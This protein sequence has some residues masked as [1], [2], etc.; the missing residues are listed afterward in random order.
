MAFKPG[1]N[2]GRQFTSETQPKKNGR[3]PAIYKQLAAMV[4]K[5][6]KLTLS[7]EDFLKL[8]HWIL[9]QPA[10]DLKLIIKD[11]ET[12]IFMSAMIAAVVGDMNN[13][14][15]TTV[16]RTYE[17]L[18]GSAKQTIETTTIAPETKY[19]LEELSDEEL[20]RIGAIMAKTTGKDKNDNPDQDSGDNQ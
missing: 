7:K 4:N 16:E 13:G 5:Q 18:F 2:V 10:A 11:P 1:N 3:K 17:R 20:N 14:S 12:P 6:V 19:N 8:Q 9:E 15:Y